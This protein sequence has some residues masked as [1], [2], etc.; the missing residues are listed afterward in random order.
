[1]SYEM[2]DCVD[3]AL[4]NKCTVLD[5]VLSVHAVYLCIASVKRMGL[6]G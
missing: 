4:H 1:M 5:S 3:N 6:L 2:P